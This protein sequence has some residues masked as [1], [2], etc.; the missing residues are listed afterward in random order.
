MYT[1]VVLLVV[2]KLH[3]ITGYEFDAAVQKIANARLKN[4]SSIQFWEE[5]VA[6]LLWVNW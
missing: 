3:M 4:F 5:S 2:T 6:C 1:R